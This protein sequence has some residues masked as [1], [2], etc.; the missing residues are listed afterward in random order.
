VALD[1]NVNA[2]HPTD[3]D[4]TITHLDV[5]PVRCSAP[6]DFDGDDSTD[7]ALFRPA[8]GGWYAPGQTS[9]FLG[10]AADTP[11]A[12]GCNGDTIAERVVFRSGA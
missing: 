8:V 12:V 7:R 4:Q 9:T 2:G 3:F 1:A 11:V 5:D 10:L 6:A